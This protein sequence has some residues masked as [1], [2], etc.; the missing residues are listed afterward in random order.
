MLQS[1]GHKYKS[2]VENS[3][4]HENQIQNKNCGCRNYNDN[5]QVTFVLSPLRW[6]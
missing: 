1:C 3:R 2:C 6:D 5:D 4:V